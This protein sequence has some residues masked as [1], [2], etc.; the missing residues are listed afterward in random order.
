MISEPAEPA[1][2]PSSTKGQVGYLQIPAVNVE[3]SASF[4]ERIFGWQVEQPNPSFE[5]PNV[6]GQWVTDR[7]VARD[8][9]I[10]MWIDVDNIQVT[11]EMARSD[12]GEVLEQPVADGPERLLATIRDP[13]GNAIGVVQH[14]PH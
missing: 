14:G 1:R 2:T 12:G 11:L 9:G 3:Q 8:G 5:A 10:L 13:A 4:Y 7:P 6:I